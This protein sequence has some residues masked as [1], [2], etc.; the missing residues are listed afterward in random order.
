MIAAQIERSNIGAAVTLVRYD[1]PF[2]FSDKCNSG[3]AGAAG[4]FLIFYNDDVRV[5]DGNWIDALL[6]YAVLD[7]VG[8]V[9]PKLL[10]EDGTIQHAGMVTGV[11]RLVGTAFHSYPA[12]TLEHFS[13]AQYTREVSLL[14]GACIMIG[15]K[16]FHE[17]NGF[18]SENA[19]INHSDVD[20][21]FRIRDK[22]LSCIYVPSACLLHIGHASIGETEKVTPGHNKKDK[23]DIFL[24][25]RWAD[26]IS[27]DPYFPP[28]M[29]D[30]IYRDSQEPFT[31]YPGMQTK[32]VIGFRDVLLISHDLTNSGAPRVVYDLS[33][34]LRSAGYYVCVASPT[35]GPMRRRLVESGVDVIID[36]LLFR[37]DSN[38]RDFA[39]NFDFAIANT[40]VSWP[41]VAQMKDTLPIYW[42]VHESSLLDHLASTYPNFADCFQGVA[43]VWAGSG[44]SAKYLDKL[45]VF[46]IRVVPYGVDERETPPRNYL[47]KNLNR[48]QP[49]SVG[50]FGS[51]EPRKGQDLAIRGFLDLPHA[52]RAGLELRLFGRTLDAA[53][54]D[55]VSNLANE[56]EN[57]FQKGEISEADYIE[58]LSKVDIVLIPSRDDTLP[59]VSLDALSM[60]KILIVS[61]AT[62]TSEWLEDGVSAYILERNDPAEISS[63]LL[64]IISDPQAWA[65]IQ[66]NARNCFVENFS[67]DG[68]SRRILDLVDAGQKV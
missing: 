8:A 61:R 14:C 37:N 57:I 23:A 56:S 55:V 64:R 27:F 24:I 65:T 7:G 53:F 67:W 6:D 48:D 43:G 28:A 58:E 5:L 26:K 59:F 66:D 54:A 47:A 60:G 29:R 12:S 49:I 10:Y 46:D 45:G 51:I 40:A 35:D 41:F 34:I 33:Q 19:P 31:L 68:Y 2:N 32:R 9:A 3:A 44:K 42:Y 50:V 17:L 52:C 62:G 38:N 16:T 21:C 63:V 18:D 30:L 36:S 4:E 25:K 22:D 20:L 1:Q 15:S 11:R 13:T 39:R